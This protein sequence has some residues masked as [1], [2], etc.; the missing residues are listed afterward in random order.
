[1]DGG[2]EMKQRKFDTFMEGEVIDLCVPGNDPWVMNQWYRWFND[3]KVTK[4]L[5]Q[6]I[7]PNTRE[8]QEKYYSDIT[9]GEDRIVLLIRPKGAD[10]FVGVT[11]LSEISLKHRRCTFALIMGRQDGKPDSIFYAMEAKSLMTEHAF[12][13]VGVERINSGQVLELIQW[14]RWQILFGYHIEGIQRRNFRKGNKVWDVMISSCLL[15]DYLRL[16]KMR[17]GALWPGKARLFELMKRLPE[18]STIERLEK[19]LSEEREKNWQF[20]RENAGGGQG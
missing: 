7:Y 14:Q 1:M 9:A 10:Y 20:L 16:K 5:E 6:G 11:S 12:E 8:K 17:Q 2:N 13:N 4:Y 18:E 15:E 19:W 3:P